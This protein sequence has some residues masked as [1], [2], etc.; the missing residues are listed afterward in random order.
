M[1]QSPDR[2]DT[3]LR[4]VHEGFFS[5]NVAIIFMLQEG[6]TSRFP[7]LTQLKYK[8]NDY[9]HLHAH[10]NLGYWIGFFGLAFGLAL[11][12]FL[13]LALSSR[14]SFTK[15]FLRSVAGIVSLVA[16][17]VCWYYVKRGT[18]ELLPANFDPGLWSLLEVVVAVA[19]ALLYLYGRWPLPGWGSATMLI[20]HHGFWSWLFFARPLLYRPIFLVFP[21]AGFCSTLAWGLYVSRQNSP[22]EV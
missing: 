15:E 16:M 18:R 8:F 1:G 3:A 22:R 21:I 7:L 6:L 11:C 19:C 20:L 13:L 2:A 4:Y 9:L 14:T 5:A 10:N 12:I 17:P